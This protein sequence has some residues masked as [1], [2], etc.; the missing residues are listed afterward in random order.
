MNLKTSLIAHWKLDETGGTRNDSHG[1][2]HLTDNN[3][4]LSA[5]GKHDTAADFESTNSENLTITDNADLSLGA[6][7]D[8]TIAFWIKSESVTALR[9]I[10]Q[11]SDDFV[12]GTA[13]EYQVY[14]TNGGNVRYNVGNGTTSTEVAGST[15][16]DGVWMFVVCWYSS[17]E[18]KIY[19]Q[20]DNGTPVSAAWTGG[21]QNTAKPFAIGAFSGGGFYYDGLIDSVS[22]WKRV[23]T[24]AERKALYNS[25]NG[26]TYEAFDFNP[27]SGTLLDS[28][29]S[30]WTLNEASG[31]R[32]DSHGSNDLTD[33]NTV[34][35]TTGKLGDAANVVRNNVEWLSSSS[36]DFALSSTEDWSFSI[37]IYPINRD[38]YYTF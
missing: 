7:T 36:G 21:T 13:C 35:S 14:H 10:L 23:L 18:Q 9:C 38:G 37:W 26:L 17:A 33:N 11:K 30:H 20:C 5:A 31:T 32:V 8:H 4:V 2:N 16:T 24:S 15:L 1:T 29:V 19:I 3:T 6:N 12:N 22:F 27:L 25:G 28:L 34:A